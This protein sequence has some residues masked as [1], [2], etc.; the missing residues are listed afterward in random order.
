MMQMKLSKKIF[1]SLKNRY[2]YNLQ[3]MRG[4]EF[5]LSLFIAL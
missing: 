3:S 4:T 5:V 1:D 2:Q